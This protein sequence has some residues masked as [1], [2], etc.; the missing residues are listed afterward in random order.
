M[1]V[2]KDSKQPGGLL[3]YSHI[4][5]L[6]AKLNLLFLR[7]MLKK[8]KCCDEDDEVRTIIATDLYL[9]LVFIIGHDHQNS[10]HTAVG[11]R[12]AD[13]NFISAT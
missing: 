11:G 6:K 1:R 10:S 12:E 5:S 8:V 13:P 9:N 2:G 3:Q 4:D 7:G